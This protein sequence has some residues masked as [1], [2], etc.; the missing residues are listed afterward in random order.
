MGTLL[1]KNYTDRNNIAVL[2][3]RKPEIPIESVLFEEDMSAISMC[4][5]HGLGITGIHIYSKTRV[6]SIGESHDSYEIDFP[7]QEGKERINRI[8]VWGSGIYLKVIFTLLYTF[9]RNV[10]SDALLDLYHIR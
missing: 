8:D 3:Y 1:Q 10:H 7:I 5:H 4:L 6:Q 9:S 2:A